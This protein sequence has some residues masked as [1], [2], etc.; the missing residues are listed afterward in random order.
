MFKVN[1]KN[2]K[3]IS[4]ISVFEFEQVN[5]VNW[6]GTPFHFICLKKN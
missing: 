3:V 6:A 2:T 1:N 5:V 4:S